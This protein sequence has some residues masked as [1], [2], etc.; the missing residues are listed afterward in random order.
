MLF[1]FF[2]HN[3]FLLSIEVF[4]SDAVGKDTSLGKIKVDP[5]DIEGGNPQWFPLEVNINLF[6]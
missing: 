4:D 6:I 2:L 5:R 1:S 3:F